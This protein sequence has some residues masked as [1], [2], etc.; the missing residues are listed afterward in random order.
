M[1]ASA[2]PLAARIRARE[3]IRLLIVKMPCPAEI[4][5][6]SYAGFDG[7]VIDTEH[8]PSSGPELEHHMR[9]ADAAG[10]PVLVR[11]GSLAPADIQQSLDAGASGV[12]VPHV[13]S[14]A[15]A[16]AV[17]AAAH[18]PPRGNRGLALTTRAGRYATTH[19]QTH[20][21]DADETQ[22]IVQIEDSSALGQVDAI[23]A[24]DGVNAVMIGSLDLSASLGR[25]GQVGHTEVTAA[26]AHI[27]SAARRAGLPVAEVVSAPIDTEALRERGA[28]ILVFVATLLVRDAF[29]RVAGG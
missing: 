27:A 5:L 15:D 24:V 4:E 1:S 19:I 14:D 17:V 2:P 11:V 9:A 21:R 26:A 8:G 3:L 6:A 18:Y 10:I 13:T 23:L 7:V 12:V 22:V 28:T 16:A 25:A 29:L 20:L